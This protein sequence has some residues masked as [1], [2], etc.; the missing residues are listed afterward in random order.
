[1]EANGGSF[2]L[3][4]MP[5]W[6]HGK[7]GERTDEMRKK[8]WRGEYVEACDM[9]GVP[10]QAVGIL[11]GRAAGEASRRWKTP[12]PMLDVKLPRPA[13]DRPSHPGLMIV[14]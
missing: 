13:G 7:D 3:A 5:D 2:F 8:N 4:G 9:I 14:V 11:L 1:M 12:P 10:S 6:Q